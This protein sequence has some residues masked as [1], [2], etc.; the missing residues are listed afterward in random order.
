[1]LPDPPDP[2]VQALLN[3]NF[4]CL[5][6]LQRLTDARPPGV[7]PTQHEKKLAQTVNQNLTSLLSTIGPLDLPHGLALTKPASLKT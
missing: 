6:L 5:D 1:M 4:E 2:T 3:K 7:A